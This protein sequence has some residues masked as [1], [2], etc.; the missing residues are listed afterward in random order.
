M[1]K[2][3]FQYILQFVS[4][5]SGTAAYGFCFGLLLMSGLGV[6]LPEDVTLFAGG[7]MSFA[8]QA[9]VHFMVLVCMAGV[10]IGDTFVFTMGSRLGPRILK[11]RLFQKLFHEERLGQV[12]EKFHE[13]GPKIL[14][15]ARFM[16]GL[17]TPT[18]FS[19]G[20]LHIK[21]RV[22]LLY[23]GSAALISVP[24][25]VYLVYYFG[26]QVINTIQIVERNIVLAIV[27]VILFFVGR[28]LWKRNRSKTSR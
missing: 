3:V 5:L 7:L 23:D 8:G 2:L 18:F 9:D 10:M 15:A 12:R 13:H 1:D 4:G 6:P 26:E 11:W 25:I 16:P 28:Y 20:M 21:F 17:R 22:F 24:T 27:L 19:A 14:F